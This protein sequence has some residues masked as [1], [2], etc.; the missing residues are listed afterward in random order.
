MMA[1]KASS[2]IGIN[3]IQQTGNFLAHYPCSLITIVIAILANSSLNEI[4]EYAWTE[5][6]LP[7]PMFRFDTFEVI[8]SSVLFSFYCFVFGYL[9]YHVPSAHVYRIKGLTESNKSWKGRFVVWYEETF[10]YVGPWL[11]IDY[12]FPRRHLL[13]AIHA[14]A[15]TISRIF[16]DVVFSLLLYDF[17]FFL[18]HYA[19]HNNRY[20]YESVHA[21]HHTMRGDI[22]AGDAI[23]HSFWDGTFDFACSVVA[24]RISG[25]HPM[26]RTIYNVIAIYLITE[27]PSTYNDQHL[28]LLRHTLST[29]NTRTLTPPS[30]T[31]SHRTT[32]HT[33]S[34][35]AHSGYDFP[36]APHNLFPTVFLGT[37]LLFNPPF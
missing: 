32:H 7:S 34:Q 31:P 3:I 5:Y 21:K 35:Q 33:P 37:T 23:R 17:F 18:G 16:G 6:L 11:V 25:A 24:L 2:H 14:G 36:Y 10:W 13:L 20:L 1:T 19:L 26:S 27:V 12:F 30:K 9:D 29:L 22:R 28:L 15:P 8:C 4:I